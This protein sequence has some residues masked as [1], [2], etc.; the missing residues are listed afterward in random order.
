[1]R[2]LSAIRN[3]FRAR[4]ERPT[5]D[6]HWRYYIWGGGDDWIEVDQA[7]YEA[8]E[9]KRLNTKGSGIVTMKR[10]AGATFE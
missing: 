7:I 10:L 9:S 1:M 6:L 3:F 5:V 8:H 2:I 4:V